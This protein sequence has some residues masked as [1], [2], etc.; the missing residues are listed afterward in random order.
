M[1]RHTVVSFIVNWP[2]PDLCKEDKRRHGTSPQQYWWERP[3]DMEDAASAVATVQGIVTKWMS[4][5]Y[6][7]CVIFIDL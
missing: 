3:M 2:I 6:L 7:S 1:R 4:C 5:G